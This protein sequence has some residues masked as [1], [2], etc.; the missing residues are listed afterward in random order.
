MFHSAPSAPRFATPIVK[1]K[2]GP[3]SGVRGA[4]R[5]WPLPR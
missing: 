4:A 5:L 1:S 2:W 3:D